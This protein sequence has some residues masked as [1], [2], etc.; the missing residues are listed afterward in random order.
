MKVLVTTDSI[1]IGSALCIRLLDRDKLVK[2][3]FLYAEV[4]IRAQVGDVENPWKKLVFFESLK[5]V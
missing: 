1:A 4:A 5:S 2:D 3:T